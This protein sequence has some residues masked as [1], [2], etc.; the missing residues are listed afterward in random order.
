MPVGSEND[1]CQKWGRREALC[2]NNLYISNQSTEAK[3]TSTLSKICDRSGIP[4]P[5]NVLNAGISM[6]KT[7]REV[8][9]VNTQPTIAF[10]YFNVAKSDL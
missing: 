3:P 1:P 7:D 4:N 2:A 5:N 9:I 10:L 6:I 8:E